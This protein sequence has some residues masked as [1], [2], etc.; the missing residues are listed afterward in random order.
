MAQYSIKQLE[1]SFHQIP[2]G[3]EGDPEFRKGEMMRT[4]L[5]M[6]LVSDGATHIL[7]DSGIDY[8]NPRATSRIVPGTGAPKDLM[9]SVSLTPE[10]IDA[11]ILTHIHWDHIGGIRYYP[12]ATVY[13]Q[14]DEVLGWLE[15]MNSPAIRKEFCEPVWAS[16][17]HALIDLLYEG[18]LVMLDGDMD[19]LFPGIHIK[20]SRFAHTYAQSIV[21]IEHMVAGSLE[22]YAIVGDLS[23]RPE[24]LVGTPNCPGFIPNTRFAV[25]GVA[26][27]LR[28]YETLMDWVKGD[29]SHVIMTHDGSWQEGP[30][31]SMAPSGLYIRTVCP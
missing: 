12:N 27:T 6:S 4:A 3:M 31:A 18:R 24:N 22:H 5:S 21:Y 19:N 26:N 30:Q 9:A 16:D 23:N 7:V 2:A 17:F 28:D 10:D 8:L 1:V 25:G 11:I 29:V 20:V 13:I 15:G 14:K